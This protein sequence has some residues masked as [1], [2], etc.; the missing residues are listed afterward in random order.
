MKVMKK[1]VALESIIALLMIFF[2]YTSVSK[3]IDL[4]KFRLAM[5]HQP[6]PAWLNNTLAKSLPITELLIAL[7][8]GFSKTRSIALYAYATLMLAFTTYTALVVLHFF[9]NTP[10]G[11]GGIISKLSWEGHF[12][13][14]ISVLLLSLMAILFNNRTTIRTFANRTSQIII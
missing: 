10:C 4:N 2:I 1:Q 6:F 14:N 11:C 12:L 8:L 7:A 3:L 5:L 9:E 13:I